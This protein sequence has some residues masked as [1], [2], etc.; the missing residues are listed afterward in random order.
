MRGVFFILSLP[1]HVLEPLARFIYPAFFVCFGLGSALQGLD[2]ICPLELLRSESLDQYEQ[3]QFI[4]PK[5][6]SS[7]AQP[8]STRPPEQKTLLEGMIILV[9]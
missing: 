9:P 3:G 1:G 8:N 5:G 2:Q 7:P 4:V 6:S